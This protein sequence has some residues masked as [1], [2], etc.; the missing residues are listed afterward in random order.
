MP[1]TKF[2]LLQWMSP[3]LQTAF[4]ARL[5]RR[6]YQKG[7]FIYVQGAVGNE[8][9]RLLSGSV[10][11]SVLRPDGRHISYRIFEAGDCFG[12]TSLVDGMPR[13][14][15]TEAY[16]AVEIGVLNRTDYRWLSANFADFDHA[17]MQLLCAQLRLVA[18]NYEGASLDNLNTRVA[19]QLL[20]CHRQ[21]HLEQTSPI[22]NTAPLV[23]LSQSELAS[24]VGASR[25]SVNRTLHLFQTQNMVALGYNQITLLDPQALQSMTTATQAN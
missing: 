15:S 14:Q 21:A 7:Q 4:L 16:S 17:I 2:D 22:E 10:K 20:N 23:H 19:K 13:P 18:L 8:L 25:Q 3:A 24:L 12:Q 9:F 5:H 11:I 1:A 6:T